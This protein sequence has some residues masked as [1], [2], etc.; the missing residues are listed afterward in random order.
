MVPI[1]FKLRWK[2][3]TIPVN[4]PG[5]F[6]LTWQTDYKIYMKINKKSGPQEKF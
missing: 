2:F 1:L 6:S 4:I 3:I 5:G